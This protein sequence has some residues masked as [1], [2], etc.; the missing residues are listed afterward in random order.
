MVQTTT[1]INFLHDVLSYQD[2]V[3]YDLVRNQCGPI[4]EEIF[5]IQ[6]IRSVQT[7]PRIPNVF[8]F[9]SYDSPDRNEI[10]KKAAFRLSDGTYQ[11]RSGIKMEIDL[12]LQSLIQVDDKL[13]QSRSILNNDDIDSTGTSFLS[14]FID[15]LTQNL[16]RSKSSYRYNEHVQ[17][18]SVVFLI[19]AGRNEFVRLNLCGAFPSISTI[20][21]LL[22]KEEKHI[23][24]GQFR[25]DVMGRH[26]SSAGTNIAFSSEDCTAIV[27]KVTFDAKTNS[28]VGFSL[29]ITEGLPQSSYFQ[30]ESAAQLEE[31]LSNVDKSSLLNLHMIQPITSIGQ[32]S[33]P[34]ILSA[35]GTNSK[36]KS[37]D[38]I[39]RWIWIFEECLSRGIRIVG[40]S[41]DGDP[42]YMKAMKLILGFFA[43]MPNI[44]LSDRSDAVQV[45]P[46]NDWNWF[47]LRRRQLVLCLQDPTHVC[48]KLR[49][50]LL[51]VTAALTVG[52][53]RISLDFL[54]DMMNSISKLKH[55]L[56]KSDIYPR[57]KQNYASCGKISRDYVLAVLEEITRFISYSFVLETHSLCHNSV[58]RQINMLE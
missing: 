41:T 48:T 18:F 5:Q 12:F 7:L 37:I 39:R 54:S 11:I 49:N 56:V 51:S 27:P 29:P 19:L 24:E 47:Y 16:S 52:D 3:F 26:L 22:D 55:G 30:T 33:S 35:Y 21:S 25:F 46:P 50:R 38:I 9:M 31:R 40:F 10:K 42:K 15:S 17:K 28:F 45:S 36:Y 14:S 43:S 34:I 2:D 57:D 20:Q 23:T 13:S 58:H 8:E 6:K 4:I 1:S 32:T 44:T 53:Q